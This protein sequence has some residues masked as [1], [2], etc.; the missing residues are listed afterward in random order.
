MFLERRFISS[1]PMRCHGCATTTCQRKKARSQLTHGIKLYWPRL[2]FKQTAKV[3]NS[4]VGHWGLQKCRERLNDPTITDRTITQFIRQY[5]CCQVMSR[6]KILTKPHPFTCASYNPFGSLHIDHI[7]PVP[8]DDKG[9][10]HILVMIDASSRWVELFPTNTTGAS[11][12]VGCIFQ[13]FGRFGTPDVIHT[14]QGPAFRNELFSELSRL[15]Q[16]EHSFAKRSCAI[17]VPCFLTH[18]CTTSGLT[19]SYLWYNVS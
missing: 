18:A 4:M 6:L 10:T 17:F 13:H 16:V 12:A 2:S 5:P 15:S 1:S 9:N 14:D 19:N 8:V 7:C 11:E 3:H